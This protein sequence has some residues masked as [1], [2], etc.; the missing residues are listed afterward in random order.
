[1]SALSKRTPDAMVVDAEWF[2]DAPDMLDEF[3][4]LDLEEFNMSVAPPRRHIPL[5]E[6]TQE[7]PEPSGAFAAKP[8]PFDPIRHRK[9]TAKDPSWRE[10]LRVKTNGKGVSTLCADM[11]NL[12]SLLRNLPTVAPHLR[13]NALSKRKEWKGKELRD[14][15]FVEINEL[16][17]QAIGITFDVGLTRVCTLKVAA[18]TEYHPVRTYLRAAKRNWDGV[19][20]IQYILGDWLGVPENRLYQRIL[21]NWFISC[22]ARA[23]EPGCKVDTALVFTGVEGLKKSTLFSIMGGEWFGDTKM[24][25][26]NKDAYLQ[27]HSHWIYEWSELNAVHRNRTPEDVKAFLSSARD[28]FRAPYDASVQSHP[29]SNV[30][31]G[32]S[33]H[34]EFLTSK[35]GNRRFWVIP[36]RKDIPEE[37]ARAWR[38]QLWGEAVAAYLAG[39]K[40]YFTREE[41]TE[42]AKN[43]EKFEVNDV[44]QILVE[45]WLH[46]HKQPVYAEALLQFHLSIPPERMSEVN[47]NRIGECIKRAGWVSLDRLSC[48]FGR[49]KVWVPADSVWLD[50][51]KAVGFLNQMYT[52]TK[53]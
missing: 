53:R 14:D 51:R 19:P 52:A 37:Q 42:N 11:I 22:V 16:I 20:R 33:N 47:A 39:E 48:A 15:H 35:T 2:E 30:F 26:N 32:T 4:S 28:S 12:L 36:V 21:R 38:D 9:W 10:N 46:K 49:P 31:V 1:M 41:E 25:I 17:A 24:D 3:L 8:P 34:G 29:R 18:E 5:E 40:W 6:E 13:L 45:E 50:K 43:N 7:I 27:L 44:W 23:M